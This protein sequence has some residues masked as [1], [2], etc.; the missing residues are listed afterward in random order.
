MNLEVEKKPES[1]SLQSVTD[2]E[3]GT[4]PVENPVL[5]S[6]YQR[7]AENV[8][9][10]ETR[11]IEQVPF[12][13]RQRVSTSA[14]FNIFLTWFSMGMALN[15]MVVGTLGTVVMRLSFLDAALCALFGNFLGC[16]A[17]GYMCTW[18]P[19]SGHRTLV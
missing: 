1:H 5:K 10:L 18:G 9:G 6:R 2:D 7:W 14:S 19:R 15:N 11:G 17:I 8:K 13:E 4:P 12:E 16:I 3:A